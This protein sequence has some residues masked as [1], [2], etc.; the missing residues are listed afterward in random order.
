M[1]CSMDASLWLYR[2]ED[3]KEPCWLFNPHQH[4]TALL[5]EFSCPLR[6]WKCAKLSCPLSAQPLAHSCGHDCLPSSVATC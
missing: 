2:D 3:A 6:S 5:A 1:S 4:P